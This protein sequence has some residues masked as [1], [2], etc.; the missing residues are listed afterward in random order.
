MIYAHV[1]TLYLLL[2]QQGLSFFL[3]FF[4][5]PNVKRHVFLWIST[6]TEKCKPHAHTCRVKKRALTGFR[7]QIGHAPVGG[8]ESLKH[9]KK[10]RNY[11]LGFV[12]NQS[13]L[14]K[15]PLLISGLATS[16]VSNL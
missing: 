14:R 1:M 16:S 3:F 5:L 6:A 15:V 10:G 12:Y 7:K 9:P 11:S 4:L 2:R 13:L 8:R